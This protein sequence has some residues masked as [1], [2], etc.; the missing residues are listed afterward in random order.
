[1]YSLHQVP[2]VL[3]GLQRLLN[4]V[5]GQHLPGAHTPCQDGDAPAAMLPVLVSEVG[6]PLSPLGPIPVQVKGKYTSL[7]DFM[8]W[9]VGRRK[10][11]KIVTILLAISPEMNSWRDGKNSFGVQTSGGSIPENYIFNFDWDVK[12]LETLFLIATAPLLLPVA[13]LAFSL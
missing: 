5:Y 8:N 11:Q 2:Q 13:R 4:E 3:L 12:M 10:S 9:G 6:V 7:F 1:M